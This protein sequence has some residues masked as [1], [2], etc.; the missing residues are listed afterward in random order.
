MFNISY[1][2]ET[3]NFQQE[4]IIQKDLNITKIGFKNPIENRIFLWKTIC[5]N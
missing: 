4:F 1:R 3:E 2:N 5:L